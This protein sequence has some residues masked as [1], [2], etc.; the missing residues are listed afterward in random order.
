[1]GIDKQSGTKVIQF[2]EMTQI[3]TTYPA[4]AQ[5]EAYWSGL[6]HGPIIPSRAD[7]DPRALEQVLEF[8]FILE[9]IA[10]GV[11]RF[12]LAGNHLNDLM[13][14]E[15]RGMPA[16][17]IFEPES[18]AEVGRLIE[19]TCAHPSCQMVRLRC[20]AG[21]GRPALFGAMFL[22]PLFDDQGLITRIV[23]CLQSQGEI[24]RQPRRFAL[25]GHRE[26]ILHSAQLPPK[27]F[28]GIGVTAGVVPGFA[29]PATPFA[30]RNQSENSVPIKRNGANECPAPVRSDIRL[31][32][33]NS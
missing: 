5:L 12:R 16:T 31:V 8:A 13:G 24:R 10:P 7:I 11:G 17:A 4:I 6:C 21:L 22:A 25:T 28:A 20:A 33:D 2:E 27:Q 14:Q 9:R 26:T 29:A 15:V 18:R 30:G 1:M 23:G 32:V 3:R 19:G